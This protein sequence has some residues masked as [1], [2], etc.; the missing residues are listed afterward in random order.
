MANAAGESW[1]LDTPDLIQQ[2]A[3]LAY[4]N[5]GEEGERFY[6]LVT[7]GRVWYEVYRRVSDQD[8]IEAARAQCI[9]AIAEYVKKNPKASQEEVAKEVGKHIQEFAAKVDAM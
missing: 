3:L 6:K 2:I 5:K 8:E 1:R 7:A 4:L 9:L